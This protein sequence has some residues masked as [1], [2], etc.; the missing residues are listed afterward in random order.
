MTGVQTCALPISKRRF[1]EL[2][3]K[4]QSVTY[5]DVYNDVVTRDRNDSTRAVAPLKQAF[6]AIAVN[7]DDMTAE[8]VANDIIKYI[9][10]DINEI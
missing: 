5:E 1:D 8:D 10:G 6:D 3:A 9:L 4:G 2:T 7:S